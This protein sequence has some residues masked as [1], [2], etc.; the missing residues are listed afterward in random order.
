MA[1]V[2][3]DGPG[4]LSPQGRHHLLGG[5]PFAVAVSQRHPAIHHHMVTVVHQQVP[6]VAESGGM[7]LATTGQAG[8]SISAAAVGAVAEALPVE[9][10]AG[11]LPLLPPS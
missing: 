1:L 8:I 7:G 3:T 11:T 4:V 5:F 6:P 9:V 10:S 2:G